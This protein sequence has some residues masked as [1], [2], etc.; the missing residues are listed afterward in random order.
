M[1]PCID[2]SVHLSILE[3]RMLVCYRCF[4]EI[5]KSTVTLLSCINSSHPSWQLHHISGY[6]TKAMWD[7][8]RGFDYVL[9]MRINCGYKIKMVV[10]VSLTG[11]GD[12]FIQHSIGGAIH[13]QTNSAHMS[14]C[15]DLYYSSFSA[16]PAPHPP[17]HVTAPSLNWTINTPSK[18]GHTETTCVR[19]FLLCTEIP[20]QSSLC[21]RVPF[22]TDSKPTEAICTHLLGQHRHRSLS[23]DNKILMIWKINLESCG[24]V[25][26]MRTLRKMYALIG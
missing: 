2:L 10:L 21:W 23:S 22:P 9:Q 14:W 6:G 17:T 3:M 15:C 16:K 5:S 12:K 19:P 8:Q 4:R 1:H 26:W 20:K 13:Q 11:V 7:M 18:T 25:K 24:T